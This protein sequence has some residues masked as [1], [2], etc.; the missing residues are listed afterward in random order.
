MHN[1]IIKNYLEEVYRKIERG[2]AREETFYPSLE[3]LISSFGQS[4][5]KKTEV[6]TLPKK[7]EAAEDSECDW[8]RLEI[9]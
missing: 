3:S 4:I 6:T 5:K 7:T 9:C 1:S 2:D 8:R